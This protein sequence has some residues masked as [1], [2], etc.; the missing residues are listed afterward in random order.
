MSGGEDDT[1]QVNHLVPREAKERAQAVADWGELSTA[2]RQTYEAFARSAGDSDVVR[3]QAEVQR[4]QVQRQSVEEQIELLESQLTTLSE[5]ESELQTR[6]DQAEAEA[7]TDQQRMSEL[8]AALDRGESVWPGHGLVEEA[9]TIN[10]CQPEDVLA[11]LREERSHLPDERF[12][13]GG[14]ESVRFRTVD[15]E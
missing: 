14:G 7:E 2:V 11:E 1:A 5:R 9:A 15:S 12:V 3:L 10:G 6:L 8:L 4:V 13:E